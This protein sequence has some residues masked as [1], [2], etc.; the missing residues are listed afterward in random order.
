MIRAHRDRRETFSPVCVPGREPSSIFGDNHPYANRIRARK[1][2][3][4]PSETSRKTVVLNDPAHKL[5][6][7]LRDIGAKAVHALA[8][9]KGFWIDQFL[10]LVTLNKIARLRRVA[11]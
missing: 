6:V 2:V 7:V 1:C 11:T 3:R 4:T 5:G 10:A 8:S 9:A